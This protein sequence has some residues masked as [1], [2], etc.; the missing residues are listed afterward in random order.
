MSIDLGHHH[1]RIAVGAPAGE[2]LIQSQVPGVS[3]VD[4]DG[5]G[6]LPKALDHL[7]GCMGAAGI[8]FDEV[9]SLV[10]GMPAPVDSRGAMALRS[11]LPSWAD[12]QVPE[13]ATSLMTK[14]FGLHAQKVTVL[15]ENDANLCLLG[16]IAMRPAPEWQDVLFVK[17][18]AGIG[19]GML[20]SGSVYRGH[21]GYAGEL[22]HT[23]IAQPWSMNDRSGAQPRKC[24]RC[25]HFDCLEI[26]ISGD[27]I[28]N[29][30]RQREGYSTSLT[31]DQVIARAQNETEHPQC[32]RAIVAAGMRLGT[33]LGE[34]VTVLDPQLVVIGGILGG[35]GEVLRGAVSEALDMHGPFGSIDVE[36][37]PDGRRPWLGVR[38]GLSL[39]G[40]VLLASSGSDN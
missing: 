15:V 24:P 23:L 28:V 33:A 9:R 17:W 7:H 39:A 26:S 25:G 31:L 36:I 38:G 8:E 18:S 40:Q 16:E 30:L 34:L 14:T 35:A 37:V 10:I 21:R 5:A 22:G 13:L 29:E 4:A 12:V 32:R 11:Y 20:L 19:L 3:D 27:A 1:A 2:P 6:V